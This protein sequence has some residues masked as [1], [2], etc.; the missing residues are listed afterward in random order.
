MQLAWIG[1]FACH[2]GLPY[3]IRLVV[4]TLGLSKPKGPVGGMDVAERVDAVGRHVTR[5]H[6]AMRSLAGATGPTPSTHR[7]R[8]PLRAERLQLAAA[9]LRGF[10]AGAV[11]A[12][13][14]WILDHTTN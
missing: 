10:I 8:R 9:A 14:D 1:V 4:P 11:H 6:P 5:F 12:L 3:M 13:L 2:E 7:W